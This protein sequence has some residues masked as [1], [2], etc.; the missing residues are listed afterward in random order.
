MTLIV[1]I[2]T[3]IVIHASFVNGRKKRSKDPLS[4]D[5]F[6]IARTILSVTTGMKSNISFLAAFQTHALKVF[7]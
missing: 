2:V 1:T 4:M 6:I 3:P 7:K 5:F